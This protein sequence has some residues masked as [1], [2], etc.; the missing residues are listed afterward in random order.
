MRQVFPDNKGHSVKC[1]KQH[2]SV[3]SLANNERM[4]MYTSVPLWFKI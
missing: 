2:F 4:K 3:C 1:R